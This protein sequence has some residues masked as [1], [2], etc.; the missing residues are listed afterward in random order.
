MT[1]DT[2]PGPGEGEGDADQQGSGDFSIGSRLWPGTSKL[3]EEMGELLQ[4][5]GKLIATA[6]S[7]EHWS[8][9]LRKMLVDEAGDVAA[10]LRF[11]AV[12]N[13]TTTELLHMTKR[14]EEKLALF[15]KWHDDGRQNQKRSR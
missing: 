5:L 1:P 14:S 7:T 9:D 2:H 4:V 13:L 15:R 12:E 10:A 11:F 3:T 6:G 8:G